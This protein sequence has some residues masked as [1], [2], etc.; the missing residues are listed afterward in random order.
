V[1][2]LNPS[3]LL[4]AFQGADAVVHIK[5]M[6]SHD[7]ANRG[8]VFAL[9]KEGT[10]NILLTCSWARVPRLVH[11]SSV[12]TLGFSDDPQHPLDE[13]H[14][15]DWSSV[16]H[17][18]YMCSK[19]AAE[20][21]LRDAARQNVATIVAHP[22]TMIGPGD[23]RMTYRLFQAIQR[24]ELKS[25]P[26]GGQ[27]MV[28]VRDVADGLC[29]ILWPD[30]GSDRYV[31][32]GE[33]LT[34]AEIAQTIADETGAKH[35]PRVI[36]RALR[37]PL[38]AAARIAGR[39][40]DKGAASLPDDPDDAYWY[41]YFSS[42]RAHTQLGWTPRHSFAMCIRDTVSDLQ[43]RSLLEPYPARMVGL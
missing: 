2:I 5:E 28:D 40:A 8:R 38:G 36:P 41:R 11:V 17:R 37:A 33:N 20:L 10:R 19:H 12:A 26:G 22:G 16:Q 23:T 3:T 32:G 24:G 31:L 43:S 39:F 34:F 27:N 7:P 13:S 21:Q 14:S 18:Q 15:P 42:E 29:R 30:S 25:V 1:D 9:N 6:V 35:A 4:P